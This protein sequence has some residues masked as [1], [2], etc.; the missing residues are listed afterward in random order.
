MFYILTEASHS[1]GHLWKDLP[2]DCVPLHF[3]FTAFVISH[4]Y[5]YRLNVSP[6]PHWA[7]QSQGLHALC[8]FSGLLSLSPLILKHMDFKT[9]AGLCRSVNQNYTFMRVAI[10][11]GV[12]L[13]WLEDEHLWRKTWTAHSHFLCSDKE[14][15]IVGISTA[16]SQ[17][18]GKSIKC[19]VGGWEF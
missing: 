13:W 4:L 8:W 7:P 15:P 16:R 9:T 14:R 12:Y 6:R 2:L 19:S 5:D 1:S 3:S 10:R 11:L 17:R 18:A